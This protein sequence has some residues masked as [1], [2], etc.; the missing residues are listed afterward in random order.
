MDWNAIPG[1]WQRLRRRF[2]TRW[3]RLTQEDLDRIGGTRVAL[4][5]R[6]VHRYGIHLQDAGTEA[7]AFVATL[8]ERRAP[9]SAS[10]GGTD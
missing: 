1:A 4:L 6:L 8:R 5:A 10:A 9:E 7:D 2:Q 3:S